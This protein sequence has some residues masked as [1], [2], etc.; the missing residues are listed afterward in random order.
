MRNATEV[1]GE[2]AENGKDEGMEKGHASSVNAILKFAL[3]ERNLINK[4]FNFLDLGCGNGWVVRKLINEPLCN[5][6]NG[7]DG[8]KQMI[9]NAKKRGEE[10][11]YIH[12]DISDY[13]PSTRFDLVHS[14]EVMYYLSDPLSV[15]KKIEDSWLNSDGRL[16]IGLD[17]YYE[18]ED[19][20][21]WEAKVNTPMLMLKE[22][23]WNDL[24]KQAGFIDV[25][26]W[27][28][29]KRQDWAGTLVVTGKK[30]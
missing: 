4:N 19:S 10:E 28:V 24:F 26:S 15:I 23:E 14:M 11:H 18:N 9:S 29:N 27:R 16:I 12:S 8:A 22:S 1:F 20:H 6:A 5:I 25:E 17:L 2:W 21:S 7:V 13:Q 3:K 30:A